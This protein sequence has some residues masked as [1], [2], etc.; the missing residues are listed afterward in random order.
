MSIRSKVAKLLDHL[1][2]SATTTAVINQYIGE[3][4]KVIDLTIDNTNKKATVSVLL[5]GE[6]SPIA[7]R[8]DEYEILRNDSSTSVR[9]KHASCDRP[10]LDAVLQ[11]FVVGKSWD[12][13]A[14]KLDLLDD[15]LG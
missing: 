7:V 4:G 9:I 3:Y 2:D 5:K 11:R 13:P 8:V 10:W 1:T 6:S 14:D 12:V 15:F